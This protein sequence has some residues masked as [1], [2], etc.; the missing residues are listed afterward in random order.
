MA[1]DVILWWSYYLCAFLSYYDHITDSVINNKTLHTA[2]TLIVNLRVSS[3]KDT[4]ARY[5]T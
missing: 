2:V 4:V 1:V 3:T 5:S